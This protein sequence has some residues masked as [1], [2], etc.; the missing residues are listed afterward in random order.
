MA[1]AYALYKIE[2][3]QTARVTVYAEYLEKHPPT[4]QVEIVETAPGA[5][6]MGSRGGGAIAAVPVVRMPGGARSGGSAPPGHGPASGSAGASL[7]AGV[8]QVLGGPLEGS[9]RIHRCRG[10]SL[11]GKRGIVF[12]RHAVAEISPDVRTHLLKLLEM[13]RH[14]MLMYTSCGWFFRRDFGAGRPPR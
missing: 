4:H 9:K 6:S 7:R 8:V 12:R 5:V 3:T 11:P 2:S 10:G 14:T 1:L 13:Q